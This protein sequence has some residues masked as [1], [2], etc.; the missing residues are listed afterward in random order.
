M[1]NLV[2][3]PSDLITS[4]LMYSMFTA[5]FTLYTF[6]GTSSF[7]ALDVPAQD[8]ALKTS[9]TLNSIYTVACDRWDTSYDIPSAGEL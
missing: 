8:Q 9:S 6:C 3:I 7:G 2:V 1:G 4:K 5:L